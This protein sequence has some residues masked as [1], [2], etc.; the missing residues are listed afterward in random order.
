MQF[1]TSE[2]YQVDY[3]TGVVLNHIKVTTA[4]AC[5]RLCTL[6]L[7]VLI[8]L[9]TIYKLPGREVCAARAAGVWQ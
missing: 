6:I 3:N 4:R 5:I 1:V 8:I 2:T 9:Y 7:C